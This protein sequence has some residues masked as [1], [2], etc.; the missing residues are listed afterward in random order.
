[1]AKTILI[2]QMGKVGS[3]SIQQG[4]FH[5]QFAQA[6]SIDEIRRC[7]GHVV[8]HS[9]SH[10]RSAAIIDHPIHATGKRELIVVSLVRE[11]IGRTI[12]AMFQN[13]DNVGH[14]LA[15]GERAY[16]LSLT[17]EEIIAAFRERQG[18]H[19]EGEVIP[20]FDTFS[21]NVGLDVFAF[22]FPTERGFRTYRSRKA[23]IAI[24][25]TENVSQAEQWLE[26]VFG[27]S[28]FIFG[29]ANSTAERWQGQSYRDFCAGFRPTSAEL[30]AYY[31]TKIMRH[32]YTAA[33][34]AAFRAK[35][36]RPITTPQKPSP[37]TPPQPCVSA[38]TRPP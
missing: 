6:N 23:K 16:V 38:R 17:V 26:R 9:H 35:W 10:E 30:D 24:L 18:H 11:L 2:Y 8:A 29:H 5:C 28:L 13:I 25:R 36:S 37:R 20:W 15:I 14:P 3:R 4:L 33:E 27:L 22:P 12:S 1:M 32:F 31:D 19:L 7:D 34:I 21:K